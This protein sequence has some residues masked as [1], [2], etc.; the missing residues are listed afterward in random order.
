MTTPQTNNSSVRVLFV[1]LGIVALAALLA[2]VFVRSKAEVPTNISQNAASGPKNMI[3]TEQALTQDS[4]NVGGINDATPP[5]TV[6]L[7]SGSLSDVIHLTATIEN[8][9]G[10]NNV[11]V[12]RSNATLYVQAF[13]GTTLNEGTC[14]QQHLDGTSCWE[15]SLTGDQ[16]VSSGV[17]VPVS[18]DP[19]ETMIHMDVP[20]A[21]PHYALD[22]TWTIYWQLIPTDDAGNANGSYSVS[23]ANLAALMRMSVD[24]LVA[25]DVT[26][27]NGTTATY[28]AVGGGSIVPLEASAPVSITVNQKGN[29]PDHVAV[30]GT[31]WTNTDN[32]LTMPVSITHFLGTSLSSY[33]AQDFETLVSG[34]PD[35]AIRVN[36]VSSAPEWLIPVSLGTQDNTVT[37]LGTNHYATMIMPPAGRVGSFSAVLTNIA[38]DASGSGGGTPIGGTY[39]AIMG[40]TSDIGVK[41]MVVN[42]NYA[43]VT[44]SQTLASGG[45]QSSTNNFS[46]I[47]MTTK[48][49]PTVV[50]TTSVGY[51]ATVIA[52]KGN[53]VYAGHNALTNDIAIIDVSS[54]TSPTVTG[55]ASMPHNTT[56]ITKAAVFGNYLY[57]AMNGGLLEVVDVTTP[58]APSYLTE[59]SLNSG[60][61]IVSMVKYG[62]YLYASDPFAGVIDIVNIQYPNAPSVITTS[63]STGGKTKADNLAIVGSY[64]YLGLITKSGGSV[65]VYSLSDPT[66]PSFVT[67]L[68]V[69]DGDSQPDFSLT[70]TK[71]I[72]VSPTK[73]T[74]I[75]VSSPASPSVISSDASLAIAG[76]NQNSPV[77]SAI[78]QYLYVGKWKFSVVD[79]GQ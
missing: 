30:V 24:K 58:S 61:D 40:Q 33:T 4:I 34:G 68:N 16:F 35:Q 25:I 12:G 6:H 47:D 36:N 64:L 1:I 3:V 57:L 66:N 56:G 72:A 42:G 7:T 43:Y 59:V 67:S 13:H 53:Y 78:G 27:N 65:D 9:N 10:V 77:V 54:P 48:S 74:V 79:L 32:S 21:L 38:S 73:L 55:Y 20:I 46:V 29:V 51:Y 28:T 62:N 31:D 69:N 75:D 22:G 2:V 17:L 8:D 19:G 23:N 50:G 76:D 45:G 44:R 37:T 26:A 39:P 11:L 41:D 14:S 15:N 63:F 70:G 52:S 71:L 18:V 60:A 49:A 5:N